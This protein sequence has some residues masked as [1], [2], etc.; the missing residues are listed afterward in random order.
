MDTET[1]QP[2]LN[3][4]GEGPVAV[5]LEDPEV[6]DISGIG[7]ALAAALEIPLAD[8]TQRAR[9]SHGL[10]LRSVPP[11]LAGRLLRLLEEAGHAAIAVP[12]HSLEEIPP[13][14]LAREILLEPREMLVRPRSKGPSI[15]IPWSEIGAISIYALEQPVEARERVNK[16]LYAV[17]DRS[18]R[19]GLDRV[20]D[21]IVD[22]K[23]R[24]FEVHLRSDFHCTGTGRL[25]RIERD[26]RLLRL[27]EEGEDLHSL[28]RYFRFID[29]AM[30]RSGA[31]VPAAGLDFLSDLQVRRITLTRV[32][33]RESI[34][35]WLWTML[36]SGQL[37]GRG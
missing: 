34:N 18:F 36:L 31:Y 17:S 28:E 14:T 11:T 1:V 33:E 32:E 4:H 13:E 29:E 22:R 19:P 23:S 35:L 30:A 15:R 2:E 10:L 6:L 26:C 9:Y 5:L 3:S 25:L 16:L 20:L 37:E 8:A 21:E 7:G 24:G 27:T 12:A